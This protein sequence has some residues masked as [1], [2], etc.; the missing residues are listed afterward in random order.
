VAKHNGVPSFADMQT[1]A[2]YAKQ[3][4]YQQL[5]SDLSSGHVP[6]LSY[7]VPDECHDMHGAP[8][9]C[10]DSNEPGTVE[11]NYLI[12]T[13]DAFVRQ[14]VNQITSSPVWSHGTNAIVVTFDEGEEAT[15]QIPAIVITNHGPR[16]FTDPTSY[17]HYSL[18]RSIEE[19]FGLGCLKESCTATPMTPLFEK[20]GSSST[21]ELPPPVVPAPDGSNTVSGTGKP[22][23]GPPVSLGSGEAWQVV[24]S[25]SLTPL[26][27]DLAGVSAA[28]ATDAWAVGEYY[29][30]SNPEV[31]ST[32]GLHWDGKRW[33]AYP[34][35]NVG[36]NENALLGVSEHHNGEAWA[37]GYFA[38]AEYQQRT[39]I[40]HF[41]GSS[42]QVVPSPNPG[43]EGDILYSVKAL[44]GG[45]AWAVGAQRDAKGIWH[46]LAEHWDGSSWSVVPM[47][48]PGNDVL[49]YAVYAVGQAGSAFPSQT[50]L[51]HW[52]G[53]KWST[54]STAEDPTES[55]DPF[56]L[57]AHGEAVTVVGARESDTAP[58]STLVASGGSSGVG[59][60]ST[61]SQGAGENDLFGV[62]TA[63]DGS[64]WAVGWY[65]EPSTLAHRTLIEHG[66]QGQWSLVESP[67]P[68]TE[69]NGL[70]AVTK[71]PHGGGLWAVGITTDS[72]GNPTPLIEFHR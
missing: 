15:E 41:D 13:G 7:I 27:N 3:T 39:L 18:L 37:V 72:E 17:N 48:D 44:R 33:T 9:W 47:V 69:E 22:V 43:A 26:D 49:M 70:A 31:L 21:P 20:T 1:P 14:T 6:N 16:S 66:V 5:A 57:N 36:P 40:E 35:P 42:W 52:D 51:E 10:L 55:L 58:F 38:N 4:P 32:L 23:K 62:T 2:A 59:L 71:I 50:L 28:S 63:A 29:P 54:V 24:Q 30:E 45:G 53:T 67:N 34:L 60:L 61:P 19:G 25:P 8:P 12:A 64:T 46:P 56:G 11:D 65:V 68:S